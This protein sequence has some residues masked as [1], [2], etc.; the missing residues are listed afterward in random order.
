MANELSFHSITATTQLKA[1]VYVGQLERSCSETGANLHGQL[2]LQCLFLNLSTCLESEFLKLDTK[3]LNSTV[4]NQHLLTRSKNIFYIYLFFFN[5]SL[6]LVLPRFIRKKLIVQLKQKKEFMKE[7]KHTFFL[8]YLT[9]LF[10]SCSVVDKKKKKRFSDVNTNVY[11]PISGHNKTP[12][13]ARRSW[14]GNGGKA[15]DFSSGE[16]ETIT[17]S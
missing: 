4:F 6:L 14:V 17:E 12:K 11:S 16:N 15:E 7:L 13:H 8:S 10:A 3:S 2:R 5:C 1:Q 9:I